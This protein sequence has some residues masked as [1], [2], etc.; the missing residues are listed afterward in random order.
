MNHSKKVNQSGVS[1]LI[2]S[3]IMEDWL[4]HCVHMQ[5]FFWLFLFS[6]FLVCR[7]WNPTGHYFVYLSRHD[8]DPSFLN[9]LSFCV[10]RGEIFTLSSPSV[11]VYRTRLPTVCSITHTGPEHFNSVSLMIW[12]VL[13]PIKQQIATKSRVSML[14]LYWYIDTALIEAVCPHATF[15]LCFSLSSFFS[16]GHRTQLPT[17]CCS[18]HATIWTDT[19]MR[20]SCREVEGSFFLFHSCFPAEHII[21]WFGLL[22]VSQYGPNLIDSFFGKVF[23]CHT[24]KFFTESGVSMQC[25]S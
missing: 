5:C 8:M 15:L 10:C 4:S 16:S 3:Y 19:L 2:V 23:L 11:S 20:F 17:V 7:A 6:S 9:K 18:C 13:F 1:M 12:R 22:S 21:W 14:W 25:L 24:T